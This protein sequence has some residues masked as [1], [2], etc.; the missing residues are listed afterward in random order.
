[1]SALVRTVAA[2][3]VAAARVVER[4]VRTSV[5]IERGARRVLAALARRSRDAKV[6][7]RLRVMSLV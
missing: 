3:L 5:Q 1:M 4:R 7:V 2:P 6:F